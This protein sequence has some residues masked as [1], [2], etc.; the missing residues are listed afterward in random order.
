VRAWTAWMGPQVVGLVALIWLAA[1]G[2]AVAAT[3][4]GLPPGVHL[5]P[6]SPASHEYAIP[7]SAA[8]S[9]GTPGPPT[10]GQLFG[11][12]ITPP[13]TAGPAA[14]RAASSGATGAAP[15][16]RAGQSP[17]GGVGS[18][19]TAQIL[20][21]SRGNGPGLL[22]MFAAAACVLALGWLGGVALLRLYRSA[23]PRAG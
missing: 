8:R 11:A 13:G 3:G 4:S 19:P 9:A 21:Q 16:A 17:S 18:Q 23:S 22:W 5:D 6:G 2:V 20:G 10:G 7:L 1:T 12:G 14:R 15:S